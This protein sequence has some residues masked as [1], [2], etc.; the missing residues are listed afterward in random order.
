MQDKKYI[1]FKKERELGEILTDT[2]K[3]IRENFKTL[4]KAL[5]KFTGPAF[6]LLVLAL[7]YYSYSTIYQSKSLFSLLDAGQTPEEVLGYSGGLIILGVI[8]LMLAV[9]LYYAFLYATVQYFI[10][11]YINHQG[12]VD[13]NE[14]KAG[15]RQNWGRFLGLSL[16]AGLITFVATLCCFIPGIYVFVPLSLVFSIFVFDDLSVTE[17]IS[18]SFSLIKNNWW[19]TFLTLL[20]ILVIFYLINIIVQL[21][22]MIYMLV[23]M[24]A[25][26]KE[27][28]STDPNAVLDWVYLSLSLIGSIAQYI[29]YGMVSIATVFI[30]FNLN[31]KKHHT[32]AYETIEQLGNTEN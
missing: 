9:T 12:E 2:F 14:I 30:Y 21:P 7:A 29:I 19:M 5:L 8:F 10:K 32:G 17:S 26:S 18:Y 25:V 24:F 20:L 15:V 1:Q 11:S 31:E 27:V 16:L 13:F 23:K 28:S 22:A 3:F 4:F 6:L